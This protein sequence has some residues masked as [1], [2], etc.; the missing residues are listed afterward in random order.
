[1]KQSIYRVLSQRCLERN[2]P[3]LCGK[4]IDLASG[5]QS[6]YRD[7]LRLENC[8]YFSSDLKQADGLDF[9]LDLTKKLPIDDASFETALLFNCLYIFEK[10]ADVLLEARRIIKPGGLLLLITPFIFNEAPEPTD[11]WRFTSQGLRKILSE[12]GFSEIK[13]IP[14]GERFTVAVSALNKFLFFR[15]LRNL[16]Y[17]TAMGLD[18][19]VPEN[20]KKNHP[21]PLGYLAIAQKQNI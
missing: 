11:Y 19:L 3:V 20:I 13:I 4:V 14:F 7:Y 10:P 12:A 17:L 9:V 8:R 18:K 21:C 15:P 16:V 5:S 6:N 2:C 1:M